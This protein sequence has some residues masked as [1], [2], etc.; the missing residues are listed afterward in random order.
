DTITDFDVTEDLIGLVEGE[1]TFEDIKIIEI[2]GNAA[3]NIIETEETLAVLDGVEPDELT[4]ELFVVT[5][6]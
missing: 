3:I 4:A 6:Q 5:T 1:L 2:D